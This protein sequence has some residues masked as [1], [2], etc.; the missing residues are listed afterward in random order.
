MSQESMCSRS[1]CCA[2]LA[3]IIRGTARFLAD[4]S[5]IKSRCLT[6]LSTVAVHRTRR[7]KIEHANVLFEHNGAVRL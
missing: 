3:G 5:R 1:I 7:L 4:P 6:T 2:S